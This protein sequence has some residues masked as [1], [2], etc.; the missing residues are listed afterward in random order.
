MKL[1]KVLQSPLTLTRRIGHIPRWMTATKER[2]SMGMAV[3]AVFGAAAAYCAARAEQRSAQLEAK[4]N[5]GKIVELALRH[6]VFDQSSQYAHFLDT[7]KQHQNQA[8]NF[9]LETASHPA[10]APSLELRAQEESAVARTSYPFLR[11]TWV[12]LPSGLP[13]TEKERLTDRIVSEQLATFGFETIWMEKPNADGSRPSIWVVLMQQI[14]DA[15]RLVLRLAS[16]IVVFVLALVFF[17]F[18]QLSSN[19]PNKKLRWI[20][21]GVLTAI[22]GLMYAGWDDLDSWWTLAKFGMGIFLLIRLG[23]TMS[24]SSEQWEHY[25]QNRRTGRWIQRLETRGGLWCWVLKKL[26]EVAEWIREKLKLEEEKIQEEHL[27]ELERPISPGLRIPIVPVDEPFGRVVVRLI[28]GTALVSALTGLFFSLCTVR[29]NQAASGALDFLS[30]RVKTD[31]MVRAEAYDRLLRLAAAREYQTRYW[32]GQQRIALATEDPSKVNLNDA[33]R[34]MRQ[35]QAGGATADEQSRRDLD[36]EYGPD[37]D[38]HFPD[39]LLVPSLWREPE[40]EFARGIGE[41]EI[42]LAWRRRAT[43]FLRSLTLFAIALYLFGQSLGMGSTRPAF[44]LAFYASALVVA[45]VFSPSAGIVKNLPPNEQAVM[46]SAWHYGNGRALYETG[47]LQ[48]AV[49]ELEQAVKDRPTFALASYFLAVAKVKLLSPQKQGNVSHIS[50][51]ALAEIVDLREQGNMRLAEQDYSPPLLFLGNRGFDEILL[52]Y[53]EADAKHVK[54]VQSPRLERMLE[55]M[56]SRLLR[57]V[58]SIVRRY[59]AHAHI[60]SGTEK[61]LDALDRLKRDSQH[62]DKAMEEDG[63]YVWLQFNLGLAYLSDGEMKK[64]EK[65]YRDGILSMKKLRQSRDPGGNIANLTTGAISDLN[66]LQKYCSRFNL[67][68]YCNDMDNY[69][70]AEKKELIKAAWGAADAGSAEISALKLWTAPSAVAWDVTLTNHDPKDV[71]TVLWF[72]CDADYQSA[73]DHEAGTCDKKL[74]P[75]DSQDDHWGVWYALP[76]FSGRSDIENNGESWGFVQ[77][78]SSILQPDCLRK[79]EYRVEF[80]LNGALADKFTRE[81]TFGLSDFEPG[82]S[83]DLDMTVCHPVGWRSWSA[84]SHSEPGWIR[85]YVSSDR[86]PYRGAFLFTSYYPKQENDVTELALQRAQ[87][88]L[89]SQGIASAFHPAPEKYGCGFPSGDRYF[90]RRSMVGGE[91]LLSRAWV[92]EDGMVHV[93]IVFRSD[94]SEM[95]SPKPQSERERDNREDCQILTSIRNIY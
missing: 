12:D 94:M 25:K 13:E 59:R 54:L 44:I 68:T 71:L 30:E 95:T 48:G 19:N 76:K 70:T 29:A 20:S 38:T 14:A 9:L 43:G 21:L 74:D 57:S 51:D 85:G 8:M 58:R 83:R 16:S 93:G 31:S 2:V 7:Q 78:Q 86:T 92:M 53:A 66:T 90:E 40:T 35:L 79:G 77:P 62:A 1:K 91:T 84:S 72:A 27:E 36:S 42:S 89:V 22:A 87:R 82:N 61:T 67:Q 75:A 47:N 23:G 65:A 46:E 34:R 11:F 45:G 26:R 39:Q 17:T 73:L 37:R 4:L 41:N 50:K 6:D 10:N 81:L 64:G 3:V 33:Q 5:Q 18:A 24:A 32:A 56:N 63:N 15:Q 55:M 49:E 88:F 80:Y 69:I 52:G 60:R 28:A